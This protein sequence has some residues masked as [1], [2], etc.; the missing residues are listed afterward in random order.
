MELDKKEAD[1]VNKAIQSWEEDSN[2]F[3]GTGA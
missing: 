2:D 1:I 3:E